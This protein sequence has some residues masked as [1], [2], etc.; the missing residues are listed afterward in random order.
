MF[1]SNAGGSSA[2]ALKAQALLL[3]RKRSSLSR[4]YFLYVLLRQNSA[5]MIILVLTCLFILTFFRG[6]PFH[7]TDVHAINRRNAMSLRSHGSH[8]RPGDASTGVVGDRGR[9]TEDGTRQG[10]KFA[11]NARI[12]IGDAG[13]SSELQEGGR[14]DGL[15]HHLR[16]TS[17]ETNQDAAAA[18]AATAAAAAAA[19]AGAGVEAGRISSADGVQ[20]RAV[21]EAGTGRWEAGGGGG[22]GGTPLTL[23]TRQRSQTQAQTQAHARVADRS[24]STGSSSSSGRVSVSAG[25]L[26]NYRFVEHAPVFSFVFFSSYRLGPSS[27]AVLGFAA[28]AL[29]VGAGLVAYFGAAWGLGAVNLGELRGML[30]RRRR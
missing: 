14:L 17:S 8:A 5:G 9:A 7:N 23:F 13:T 15:Q 25:G 11:G 28:L 30:R 4:S 16:G 26:R 24:G 3:R 10:N 19:A 1:G 2:A 29:L 18:A 20:R 27:V 21:E 6:T 22:S 12:R